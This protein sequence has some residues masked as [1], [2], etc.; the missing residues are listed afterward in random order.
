MNKNG[1]ETEIF[2]IGTDAIAG[3]IN[4]GACLKTGKCFR[5]NI[6]NNFVDKAKD[7]D[8]FVFG[9]PVY[10]GN[11]AGQITS[12]LDRVFHG[13]IPVVSSQY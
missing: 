10:F 3:C 1:I 5:D 4:C 11:A 12:F 6:V 8:G 7:S 13:R 2:Q 9:T